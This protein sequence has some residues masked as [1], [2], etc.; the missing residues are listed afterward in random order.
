MTY[1]VENESI[2]GLTDRGGWG[3]NNLVAREENIHG[4]ND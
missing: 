2:P 4:E 1:K 3:K